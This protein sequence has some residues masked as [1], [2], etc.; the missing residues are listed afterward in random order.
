MYK[1]NYI[2]KV[3]VWV[4]M[5]GEKSCHVGCCKVILQNLR[6]FSLSCLHTIKSAMSRF[7]NKSFA[8]SLFASV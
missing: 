5:C 2:V 8:L 1:N 6:A 3:S 7:I 4:N